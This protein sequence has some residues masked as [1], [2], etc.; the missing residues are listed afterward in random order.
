MAR[1]KPHRQV[2][3]RHCVSS[4]R[5]TAMPVALTVLWHF[6]TGISL[7]LSYWF[8]FQR[9][10]FN[11]TTH[12]KLNS[13]IK[14]HICMQKCSYINAYNADAYSIPSVIYSILFVI[15]CCGGVY[16]HCMCC[17]N[18]RQIIL[19]TVAANLTWMYLPCMHAYPNTQQNPFRCRKWEF[20]ASDHRTSENSQD[21]CRCIT[22]N[23]IKH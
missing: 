17:C 14:F 19:S 21:A 12:N 18:D 16:L 9:P 1:Q 4:S 23:P 10:Q 13:S 2:L 7:N 6:A 15:I 8:S 5:C 22:P 3:S 11:D 20:C